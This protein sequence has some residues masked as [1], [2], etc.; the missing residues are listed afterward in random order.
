M[1][2]K[3]IFITGTDTGV[4]KTIVTAVIAK[5]MREAGVKVGVMKPVTSG[6]V[7]T[8]EKLVSE[9]AELLK[10]AAATVMTDSEICPYLLREPLAPSV[11]AKIDGID[12]S[13][14][15]IAETYGRIADRHDFVLVEGAGGLLVPLT[16]SMLVS[17]LIR[18]LGLPALIVSR[19]NLGTVNHTLMTCMC[20]K[21]SRIDLKGI[22]I[23]RYPETPGAA[24]EYAPRM[25]ESLTGVRV[26]GVFPEIVWTNPTV[27][28]HSI[29]RMI[30][31]TQVADDLLK[32]L[33]N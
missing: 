18:H 24:E 31:G 10:W 32:S 11:A 9:D 15:K 13:F 23:N 2:N 8:G 6:C 17:D 7:A 16:E 25:I 26:I 5:L 29:Y 21:Y 3:G 33:M 22:I 12:I 20:A 19:P 4:G 14:E 27:Q 1:T 30:R 28:A